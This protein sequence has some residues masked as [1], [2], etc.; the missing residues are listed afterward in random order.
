MKN[1][2]DVPTFFVVQTEPLTCTTHG[3]KTLYPLTD[4]KIDEQT[5]RFF[6][7]SALARKRCHG[8]WKYALPV[9]A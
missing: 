6:I 3:D 8:S 5:Q 1:S 9:T 4:K 2:E 7:Y